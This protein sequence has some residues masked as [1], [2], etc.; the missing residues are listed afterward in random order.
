MNRI[1]L[2]LVVAAT[3]NACGG[4]SDDGEPPLN[5]ALSGTWTGSTTVSFPGFAPFSYASYVV[6]AVS[7]QTATAAAVCPDG[8]GSIAIQGSGDTAEWHGAYSCAPVAL[9]ACSTVTLTY[10]SIV[11]TLNGSGTLSA[12]GSGVASG[13]GTSSAVTLTFSGSK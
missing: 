11:A 8:S 3:L 9:G 10:Q 6:I 1:L 13:C 2:V 4:S 12:V 5:P 7:G